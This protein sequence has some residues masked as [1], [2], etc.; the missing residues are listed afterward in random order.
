MLSNIRHHAPAW[1]RALRRRRRTLTVLLLALI[2][3][4]ILPS[5][6]PASRDATSVVVAA[7]D[8]AAGTQLEASDLREVRVASA[9]MPPDAV[10][11]ADAVVGQRSAVAIPAGTAVLPGFLEGAAPPGIPDGMALLAVPAPGVLQARLAPGA[12]VE[13]LGT[14]ADPGRPLRISADVVDVVAA[15]AAAIPT[16]DGSGGDGVVLVVSVERSRAGDLAQAM[17]EGWFT[18]SIIG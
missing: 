1:R 5:L 14:G 18:V 9:V 16:L 17:N 2:T 6:L 10:T 4:M 13:I 12:R 15:D 7:Q 8:L 3:A 11:T